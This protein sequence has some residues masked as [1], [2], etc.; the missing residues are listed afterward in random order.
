MNYLFCDKVLCLYSYMYNK[1]LA[2]QYFLELKD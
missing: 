2:T 1:N